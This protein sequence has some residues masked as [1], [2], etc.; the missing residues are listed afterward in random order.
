MAI[1]LMQLKQKLNHIANKTT[2]DVEVCLMDI[3]KAFEIM[4]HFLSEWVCLMRDIPL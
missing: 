3:T 1:I 4:L 2:V